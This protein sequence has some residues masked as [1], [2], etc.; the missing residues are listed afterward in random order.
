MDTPACTEKCGQSIKLCLFRRRAQTATHKKF[1][2]Q[3]ESLPPAKKMTGLGEAKESFVEF[4][5]AH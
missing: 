3:S 4:S 5:Q 1:D 2:Y